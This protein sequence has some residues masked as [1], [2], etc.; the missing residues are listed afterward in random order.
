MS[1]L[2]DLAV[3]GG[4]LSGTEIASQ[5]VEHGAT[6]LLLEAGPHRGT[7]HVAA[8]PATTGLQDREADPDFRA[9]IPSASPDT[10]TAGLRHRYGGRGLYWRG[11]VLPIEDSA[12]HDWPEPVRLR[13]ADLGSTGSYADT[14]AHLRDWTQR[15]LGLPAHAAEDALLEWTKASG[16]GAQVT[17]RA[18]RHL[19][20]GC[21][22]AYSAASMVPKAVIRTGT[23]V[24]ALVPTPDCVVIEARGPSGRL[25]RICAATVALCAGTFENIALVHGFLRCLGLPDQGS[26]RITDHAAA[27]WVQI[28]PNHS[29]GARV[30]VGRESSV[31]LGY[32]HTARSNVF[33]ESTEHADHQL[34]DVWAMAEQ[35]PVDGIEVR[36][37]PSGLRVGQSTPSRRSYQELLDRQQPVLDE[38]ADVLRVQLERHVGDRFA[39]AHARALV[40]PGRAFAYQE[41]LGDL[42]HESGGL[43]LGADLVDAAG[44]LRADRRILVAGPSIFPRAGAANP[45]LTTLALARQLPICKPVPVSEE[46]FSDDRNDRADA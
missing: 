16:V 46:V 31:Y 37:T 32:Q 24:T 6:V 38:V 39:D 1:R 21:W 3:V 28:R 35:L 19:A 4:G 42:D 8:D 20:D 45:S 15:D 36:A 23:S 12:L 25:E 40:Q 9:S 10:S 34:L 2:Q 7:S 41:V 27:G 44:R 5:A 13:L 18:V 43:A 29:I 14:L 33:V 30:Q 17:P 11:I 22:E 26:T